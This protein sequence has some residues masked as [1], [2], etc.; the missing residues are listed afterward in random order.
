[1]TEDEKKLL[2]AAKTIIKLAHGAARKIANERLRGAG[3]HHAEV[4]W[5]LRADQAMRG[6]LLKSGAGLGISYDDASLAEFE[7]YMAERQREVEARNA[8]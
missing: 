6:W 2:T 3:Y 5:L 7:E 8:D 4:D 1:M